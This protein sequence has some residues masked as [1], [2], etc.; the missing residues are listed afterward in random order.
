MREV[1]LTIDGEPL[2]KVRAQITRRGNFTPAK[3]VADAERIA[4]DLRIACR[5]R[6]FQ[7]AI[8][9]GLI[10]YR[11]D[12]H[13]IDLDN[14]VKHVLDAGNEVAWK[15]DTQIVEIHAR[16]DVD[17]RKPRTVIAIREAA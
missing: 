12:N 6:P 11:K 16:K 7:G 3:H 10:F 15:D 5:H 4:W 8:A 13:V 2:A 14:M 1:R 9:I 17:R